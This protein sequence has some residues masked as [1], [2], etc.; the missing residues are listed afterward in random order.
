MSDQ[1][2][3]CPYCNEEM[4]IYTLDADQGEFNYFTVTLHQ[5]K[6]TKTPGVIS[7]SYEKKVPSEK[8]Y[9]PF[10]KIEG[11][12]VRDNIHDRYVHYCESCHSMVV[13]LG[14]KIPRPGQDQPYQPKHRVLK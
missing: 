4:E 12:T 6:R 5:G 8:W 2:A 1:S 10:K 9:W 11:K 3:P 14:D 13:R 7:F